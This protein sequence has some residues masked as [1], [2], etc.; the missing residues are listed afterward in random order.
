VKKPIS[1]YLVRKHFLQIG[2][3]RMTQYWHVEKNV[4]SQFKE[5]FVV[6]ILPF[7]HTVLL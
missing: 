3:A 7:I 5:R 2:T 1:I 4:K 6:F